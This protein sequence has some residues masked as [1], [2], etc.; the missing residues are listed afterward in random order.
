MCSPAYLVG[1]PAGHSVDGKVHKQQLLLL[2]LGLVRRALGRGWQPLPTAGQFPGRRPAVHL[3]QHRR[4]CLTEG[5]E[6]WSW[7]EGHIDK[8]RGLCILKGGTGDNKE[9]QERSAVHDLGLQSGQRK[10]QPGT[11]MTPGQED[12]QAPLKEDGQSP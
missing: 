8:A 1:N 10:A 11:S 9:K 2:E 5:Q 3:P 12:G 4:T 7:N 6:V